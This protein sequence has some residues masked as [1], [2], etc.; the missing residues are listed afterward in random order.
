[1]GYYCHNGSFSHPQGK[2]IMEGCTI[3]YLFKSN[4]KS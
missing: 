1:M 4:L 2:P 3:G